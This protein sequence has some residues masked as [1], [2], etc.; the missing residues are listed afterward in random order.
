MKF[1]LFKQRSAHKL[2]LTAHTKL[3]IH[4]HCRVNVFIILL[5]RLCCDYTPK[6]SI[7]V[8]KIHRFSKVE[9]NELVSTMYHCVFV[10][11]VSIIIYPRNQKPL[12][13]IQTMTLYKMLFFRLLKEQECCLCDCRWRDSKKDFT[14]IPS[15]FFQ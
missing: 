6:K 4:H 10:L 8:E 1:K 12:L 14:R 2:A 7:K 9:T 3:I 13:N 11:F 5:S 15:D